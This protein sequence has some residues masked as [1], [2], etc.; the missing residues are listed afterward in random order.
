MAP[1]A[2]EEL[3]P[4]SEQL[5]PSVDA[6][7]A[8]T[9]YPPSPEPRPPLPRTTAS[10]RTRVLVVLLALSL[11]LVFYLGLVLGSAYLVYACLA[12]KHWSWLTIAGAVGS[13]ML[14]LFLLKGLFKRE[15]AD[16][17][18]LVEVDPKEQQALSAFIG[19][20][21]EEAG[22]PRPGR[23][24]IS[25][26]VNAGVFYPRSVLSL[27][28]PVRK[29]LVIGLGLVNVLTLSE[30]KAVLAHEF[31][32]FAQSSMRLGRYVYVSNQ[33]IHDMVF[34]RDFWDRALNQWCRV[35]L[36]LS[37]PAWALRGVVWVLRKLLGWGFESINRLNQSLSRQMEFDADLASVRLTGSDALISALWKTERASLAFEMAGSDLASIAMHGTHS[38]D[39]F[40]HQKRSLD[41]INKMLL[42][43]PE[44]GE[45][46]PSLFK[47][48]RPGAAPHFAPSEEQSAD[49]WA[50]HPS[51]YDRELN[52]KKS[53]VELEFDE[54]PAW[55]LFSKKR[56]LRRHLT[57]LL[58]EKGGFA[59]KKC[60]P[61]RQVHQQILEERQEMEQAEHY[62][63]LYDDRFVRPGKIG[64]E[65]DKL[66]SAAAAGEL[67]LAELRARVA[68]HSG[69]A[70]GDLI[71][72]RARAEQRV[73]VLSEL[74]AGNIDRAKARQIL[75]EPRVAAGAVAP[76]LERAV[77]DRDGLEA[78][79]RTL[80]RDVFRY[81]AAKSLSDPDTNR[82]LVERYRF[83]VRIQKQIRE[84]NAME[85]KLGPVL[86][87]LGQRRELA[88][89][90][91]RYVV[92]TFDDAREALARAIDASDELRLPSLMHLDEVRTVRE[93]VL[94][95]PLVELRM[96]Q[97][98]DGEWASTVVRQLG[99]VLG[100]LRKL[101][102]KNLGALLKL[103]ERLDPALYAAA[104]EDDDGDPD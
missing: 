77:T 90:D 84:L 4:P 80:D 20:L 40:Y 63:G 81:F 33:V 83:L 26:D 13:A 76:L 1:P 30:L 70:L 44:L 60:L 42:E 16:A 19:K 99:R 85:R 86:Q 25:P 17:G 36:R 74:E 58:Y 61:A 66:K 104:P 97:N 10:Y 14:F 9:F 67:D 43:Q 54:R 22:S 2:S 46:H 28:Y 69:D 53:Y 93:F 65:L 82:E 34:A 73:V 7:A 98:L 31:G 15:R 87:F 8:L 103:Q 71:E 37:F 52:A 68:R 50:S 59:R 27:F 72:R 95:E 12:A 11:F 78:E 5:P 3:P 96:G 48:Y 91:F 51:N 47:D 88:E 94:P 92:D 102:F 57:E 79:I 100:R 21:C 24:Y 64:A 6:A 23:I 45:K 39:V 35:D 38:D 32:H 41:R 89:A 49:M 55:H 101:H 56:D 75:D 29:N 18:T 62:H